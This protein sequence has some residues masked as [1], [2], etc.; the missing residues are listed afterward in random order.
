[1]E[2]DMGDLAIVVEHDG[3]TAD[4]HR[5]C[6]HSNCLVGA[7]MKIGVPELDAYKLTGDELTRYVF[8][9]GD[10]DV[11]IELTDPGKCDGDTWCVWCG[12]FLT[13]GLSCE[14]P[15]KDTER[16]PLVTGELN[17]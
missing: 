16:A 2:M 3:Q 6:G 14:C 9:D 8:P 1:M 7:L 13:H 5:T 11:V 15:D 17:K 4:V 12:D 10:G